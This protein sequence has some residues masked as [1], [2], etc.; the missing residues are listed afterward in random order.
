MV[1]KVTLGG[2][3]YQLMDNKKKSNQVSYLLSIHLILPFSRAL[4][5]NWDFK[6]KLM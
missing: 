4:V 2:D 3:F 5:M 6:A 1:G